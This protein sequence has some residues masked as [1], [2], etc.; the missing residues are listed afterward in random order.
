MHHLVAVLVC[1][2]AVLGIAREA[3]QAQFTTPAP[4]P[5]YEAEPFSSSELLWG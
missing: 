1:A 4:A 5:N 3:A 2:F